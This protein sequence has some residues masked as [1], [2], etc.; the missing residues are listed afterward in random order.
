MTEEDIKELLDLLAKEGE[1][2]AE[3]A[4]PFLD[5]EGKLIEPQEETDGAV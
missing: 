2:L 5:K 3:E 4:K 1:E